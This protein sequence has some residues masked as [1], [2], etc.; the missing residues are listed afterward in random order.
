MN[1]S[2]LVHSNLVYTLNFHPDYESRAIGTELARWNEMHARPLG[3]D[4]QTHLN[5]SG[6]G[7]KA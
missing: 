7:S 1:G 6:S 5:H 4:I 3:K 2:S